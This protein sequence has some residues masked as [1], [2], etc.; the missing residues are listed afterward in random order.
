MLKGATSGE[1]LGDIKLA[2]A[3]YV[4]SVDVKPTHYLK[5]EQLI[6]EISRMIR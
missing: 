6:S 2:L 5:A 3:A 4:K 1:V